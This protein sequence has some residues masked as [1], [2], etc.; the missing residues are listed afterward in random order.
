MP[1]AP[2]QHI[3][4]RLWHLVG[5]LQSADPL[6]RDE[7]QEQLELDHRNLTMDLT[8]LREVGIKVTFRRSLGTYSMTWPEKVKPLRFS[9]EQFFYL[10]YITKQFEKNNP[11]KLK[12]WTD[13]DQRFSLAVH[14]ETDAVYDCGPAYGIDQGLTPDQLG[15]FETCKQAISKQKKLVIQYGDGNGA[16]KLRVVH[17]YKL[18]HTPVS[19]YLVAWCEERSDFRS[20]KISRIVDYKLLKERYS[21]RKFD[22]KAHLGD[23][24]WLQKGSPDQRKVVKVLFLGT[25]AK[26]IL[27]Y[28]FHDTQIWESTEKGT[29]ATWTLSYLGEF[30]SWLMQW[31]GQIEIIE[32]DELKTMVYERVER[33][34]H[35]QKIGNAP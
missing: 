16:V 32:P 26:S 11:E 18:C 34:L 19:W 3:L 7:L 22:I 13:L 21:M 35:Q 23:A 1:Q 20:F 31:L 30:C 17:P 27:E 10:Y 15:R 24:W 4:Q 12:V 6:T 9:S 5:L 2:T 29:M 8:R 25:A 33:W 14:G 28:K